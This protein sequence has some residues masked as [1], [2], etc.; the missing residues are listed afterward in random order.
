MFVCWWFE[1]SQ[2]LGVTSGLNTNSTLSVSHSAHNYLTPTTILLQHNYFKHTHTESHI[3]LRNLKL[4]SLLPRLPVPSASHFP[5]LY[6]PPPNNNPPQPPVPL[7]LRLPVPS[8]SP[9][10][11]ST[12]SRTWVCIR[13]HVRTY[14]CVRVRHCVR[15][16][17]RVCMRERERERE[18]EIFPSPVCTAV[19]LCFCLSKGS[20]CVCVCAR[21][22]A[23]VR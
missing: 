16:H 20:V 12:Y 14:V 10:P 4:F 15:A 21:A 3:F 9:V 7:L 2:L 6:L 23:C 11:H 19:L 5:T 18:R 13:V 1:P 8:L 22:R 17:A